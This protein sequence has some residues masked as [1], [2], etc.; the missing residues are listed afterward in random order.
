MGTI[1]LYYKYIFI[2][3]PAQLMNEQRQLCESLG[4]KGRIFVAHE[5]I[6]GT[7]G[8]TAESVE[9]YKA[10]MLKIPL[11]ADIDFKESQG[12]AAYFPRL[13]IKVKKEIVHF[14][15][16]PEKVSAAD[17]GIHLTPEEVQALLDAAPEDLILLDTRNDYESRVGTFEHDSI[18]TVIPNTKTFREFPQ[19]IDKNLE[20]FKGKK[21]VMFCTG[22]VRCER[23][24]AYLKEK[25]VAE[26]VYQIKGGI[27]RYVEKYPDG[28]FRGKNYVFDGR[29]TDKVNGDILSICEHCQIPYDEYTNCVNAACNRQIIVCPNCIGIYH[30][31][32]SEQCFLL[33]QDGKVNVRKVPHKVSLGDSCTL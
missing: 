29:V 9:L 16:D 2:E 11:F 27:H 15:L 13:Q 19:F 1:V 21:V 28:Y 3:D 31:T 24:S 10:H 18:P 30:N 32:C 12:D 33:V 20:T 6:N 22:G 17:G 4:L 14:G 5:G 8:G 23:A 7:L 26:K 25:N